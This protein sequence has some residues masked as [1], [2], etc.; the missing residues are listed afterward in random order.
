MAGVKNFLT[1]H[2][3][4][5]SQIESCVLQSCK[6]CRAE[7]EGRQLGK[8][9]TILNWTL[10]ISGVGAIYFFVLQKSKEAER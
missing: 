7:A 2:P 6:N 8:V 1:S 9:A 10:M 5:P 4:S 3:F